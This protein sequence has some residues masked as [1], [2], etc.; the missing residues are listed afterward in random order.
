V[1]ERERRPERDSE[2]D[3]QD[4]GLG[5]FHMV[6]APVVARGGRGGL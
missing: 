4:A 2:R 3:G 6:L 5:Q 1:H